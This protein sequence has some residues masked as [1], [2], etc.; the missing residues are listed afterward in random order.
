[1]WYYWLA[2]TQTGQFELVQL[3]RRQF[4]VTFRQ[5]TDGIVHP[6]DL[7]IFGSADHAALPNRT[8]QLITRAISG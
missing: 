8:E 1:M 5:K 7:I 2:K 6:L 4:G 3:F